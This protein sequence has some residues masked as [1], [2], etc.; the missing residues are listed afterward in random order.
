MDGR[1]GMN[2]MIVYVVLSFFVVSPV[3][4]AKGDKGHWRKVMKELNLTSDQKQRIKQISKSHRAQMKEKRQAIKVAQEEFNQQLRS[5]A[6]DDVIREA[7][8]KLEALKSD[9]ALS[10]FEQMMLIR[11]VL[12]PE[13]RAQFH[14]LRGKNHR[15]GKRRQGRGDE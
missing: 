13:Q 8:T 4:V 11:Q 3:V 14:D 2:R 10:R 9:M 7:F 1:A 15:R 5:D 12:L 6:K